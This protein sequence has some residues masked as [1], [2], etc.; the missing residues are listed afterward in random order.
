MARFHASYDDFEVYL[1]TE[2][3]SKRKVIP[4]V[5][6][7]VALYD[8]EIYKIVVN[9]K[10][11]LRIKANINLSGSDI[12]TLVLKPHQTVRIERPIRDD[13]PPRKFQ[14]VKF[15]GKLANELS[16]TPDKPNADEIQIII[17][18]EMPKP[19]VFKT[20]YSAAA[21]ST[22][23]STDEADEEDK[24]STDAIQS[25]WG[26]DTKGS[27][28]KRTTKGIKVVTDHVDGSSK[29]T[30]EA[31][32]NKGCTILS[33]I[34]SNQKWFECENFKT[35]GTFYYVIFLREAIKKPMK[36]DDSYGYVE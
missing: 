2:G 30:L 29:K 9:N 18:P 22:E 34:E 3:T 14:F 24:W 15:G 12:G 7:Q 17:E 5:L 10:F 11:G 19:D 35:K 8:N 36:I 4:D 25:D 13:L 16:A 21:A 31:S 1:E 32:S 26:G 28:N 6:K 33:S 20:H 27:S 23:L